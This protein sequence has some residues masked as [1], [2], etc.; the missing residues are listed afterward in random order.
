[1][2]LHSPRCAAFITATLTIATACT[3]MSGQ[4]PAETQPPIPAPSV[5]ETAKDKLP[6]ARDVINRHVK[7]IGGEEVVRKPKSMHVKSKLVVPK[8]DGS[9]ELKILS[10]PPDKL[11]VKSM[12][13]FG[14]TTAGFDGA[15]GWIMDPISGPRLAQARQLPELR[16]KADFYAVLHDE[17]HYKSMTTEGI[18][19]FD[20]RSCYKVKL[21]RQDDA[22]VFE[23]FDIETGLLAGRTSTL[24][25]PHGSVEQTT[26]ESEYKKF[27][28]RMLATKT[29][30][31]VSDTEIVVTVQRVEF[32]T[33][34]PSTF[35]LPQ[36]VKALLEKPAEEKE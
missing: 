35:D 13:P 20:K 23:Y 19:E 2:K 27:G 25:G 3:A 9:G 24:E 14:T 8:Q 15:T 34:E 12:M 31:K 7:A 26:I 33:L 6:S 21:V 22:E 30:Q 11:L 4:P 5:T 28:E 32:D 16:Q 29:V 36:E 18:V 17:K 1:M 10:A